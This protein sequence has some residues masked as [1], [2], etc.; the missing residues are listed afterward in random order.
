MRQLFIFLVLCGLWNLAI[1]EETGNL[2]ITSNIRDA[3]IYLNG[4]KQEQVTPAY[5]KKQPPGEYIIEL[6]DRYG[7]SISDKV[8]VMA[9]EVSA[10]SMD[11]DVSRL[12]LLTNFVADSIFINGQFCVQT[13]TPESPALFEKLPKGNYSIRVV[14]NEFGGTHEDKFFLQADVDTFSLNVNKLDLAISTNVKE[15]RIFINGRSTEQLTPAT[16]T[17]MPEGVYEIM[18]A[19]GSKRAEKTLLLKPGEYNSVQIDFQKSNLWKFILGGT[20]AVAAGTITYFVTKEDEKPGFG[21]PPDFPG[22]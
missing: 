7:H 18:L 20:G 16:L 14:D 15:A 6:K 11:Y 3:A 22:N 19:K 12:V 5:F 21:N 8:L 9:N 13:V 2:V 4:V 1:A 10:I 17:D